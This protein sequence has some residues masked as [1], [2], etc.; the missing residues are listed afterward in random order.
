MFKNFRI[1]H[2]LLIIISFLCFKNIWTP[3]Y[4]IEINI[5]HR[6]D[7]ESEHS[8]V[9]MAALTSAEHCAALSTNK[10]TSSS[11][12]NRGEETE[13]KRKSDCLIAKNSIS[14]PELAENPVRKCWLWCLLLAYSGLDKFTLRL[15]SQGKHNVAIRHLTGP[16]LQHH[17]SLS[18]PHCTSWI[19]TNGHKRV[20]CQVGGGRVVSLNER[21]QRYPA[22]CTAGMDR[23]AA[24]AE[25]TD[26]AW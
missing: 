3:Q 4:M 10:Q 25:I 18:C 19:Q 5:L 2:A 14:C 1:L 22:M 16:V 17:L 21:W 20:T 9:W 6:T 13:D 15:P 24:R 23:G 8:W 11:L 7:P 26:G 12:P